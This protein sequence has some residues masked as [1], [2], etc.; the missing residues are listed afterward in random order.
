MPEPRFTNQDKLDAIVRELGYRRRVYRRR[1]DEGQ[2][3]PELANRQIAI[4]ESIAED[5]RGKAEGERLL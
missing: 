1:V 5:Y 3:T 4:F 2:M